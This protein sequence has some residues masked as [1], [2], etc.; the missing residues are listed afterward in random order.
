MN[1]RRKREREKE[2][3]LIREQKKRGEKKSQTEK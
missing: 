3:Q 1:E 2:K